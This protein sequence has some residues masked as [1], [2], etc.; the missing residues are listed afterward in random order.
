MS[1]KNNLHRGSCK[2]GLNLKYIQFGYRKSYAK[3]DLFGQYKFKKGID[4]QAQEKLEE[5]IS[6]LINDIE[7]IRFRSLKSPLGLTSFNNSLQHA[8]VIPTAS[9]TSNDAVSTQFSIGFDYWSPVHQ[10]NN[11]FWSIL[12]CVPR[13][14]SV[15]ENISFLNP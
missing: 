13:E 5:G 10:D 14:I 15:D 9:A 6:S 3:H 11:Y 7:S 4:Q 8:L 12:G 2:D 1:A